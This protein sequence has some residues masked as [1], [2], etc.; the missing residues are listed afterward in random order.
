MAASAIIVSYDSF[1]ESVGSPP[2]RVILF[3]EIPTIIPSIS[4]VAPETSTTALIISSVALVIETTIVASPTRLCGLVPYLDSDSDSPDEMDS[5]EYITPLPATSPFLYT[6]SSEASDSSD[7][8]LLQDPYAI[9][10][11]RW[12]CRVTSRRPYRTQP[13]GPRRVMTVRKKVGPLPARRLSW[14]HV[15]PRS[16]DHR[17]SSSSSPTDSSPVHSSGLD[18]TGQAHSGSSTRVVSPRLGYLPVRATRHSEAFR[19][20]CAALLSIFYPPTTSESSSGDSSER[21]MHSSSHSAGPSC[22]RCRSSA[23]FIPSSTLVMG[24]LAPTHVD[25]LPPR[26]RFRDSYSSKTSMDEDTEI[27]TTETEDGRELDIVDGDDVRDHIEVDPRDDRRSLRPVLEIRLCWGLIQSQLVEHIPVDMDGA[28]R[29]FYHHMSKVRV[30]RIVGIETTQR[31][32]EADQMIASEARAERD[33]VD[34]LRLHMSRSQEEFR[35]IHDDCDDLMRK[36]RRTMT[37]TRSGM[38]PAVIEEMINRRVAEALKAHE[39]NRNLGLENLNGNHNCGNGNGRNGNGGNGNGQGGNRNGDGRG[40]MPVARECTYQ[41]FMKCQPLNFKR[42]EGVVGLIRW[43]EKD[44]NSVSHQKLSGKKEIMKLMT[45]VYC[46]R[47]K[48]QK[49]ETKLWNLSLKNNDMATYTQRFQELT[50]MCTKMVLEEEDQVER[51]IQGFPDNIQGSVMATEPTRLQD[52]VRIANNMMD[53]KLKGYVVRNAENKRRLDANRRDDRG[54]KPS[55]K[56]QDT[57]DQNVTR[58]YTVDNNET[59][60]MSA[61]VATTQGT[62]GPNQRVNTCFECGAPGHYR[63]DCPKIKNQNRG[64]KS[65]ILEARGKAYVLGGGDA[66]LGSNIVTGTFILNDHRAYMLFDLGANRSFVSNTFSTLLD[67]TPSALDVSYAVELADGRTSETSVVLRGCTLGLLGHPFTIDLMPIDLGSFDVIIGMDWLAKNHAVIVCDEKIVRIPYGNEILIVQ[68]DKSDEKKSILSIISCVKAHN[69]V[70]DSE[71][72][73]VDPIKIESIKDWESPK[74]PTEI[75]QFLG[76]ASYYRRF[77]KGF[78]KIS[79]PMTKLTQKSMK[80][81]WDEKEETAF[82]ILK[83]KLCSALIFALPKGSENFMV[84]CDASHKGLGAVLIQR[85]KVIAYASCQLKIYEKNYTMHDLELG[86]VVFALKMY[87][88]YLYDTRCVVSTDHKSLQHI[89]DQN[90]LNMRQRRWLE[91]L[92][93]YDYEIRYH[94]GKE[95]VVADA[96]SRKVR[97][98]PLRFRALVLTIGLNLPVQILNAQTEARKEGNYKAEDLGGMIKKLESRSDGTICLKNRSWIPGFAKENDSMEKLTRHYL[99]ESLQESFGTQLDMSTTYHP[100]TD[101]QNERTIQTLEDMLCACVMDF[102]KGW[103]KHLPLIEFS[104]NN[105][106]HTSIKAAQFEA[107]YGRKFWSPVCWAEVGDAQ[108]GTVAYRLELPEQ[109]SRVQSTFYFSNLK[110][111]LSDELLAIPLDEIHVDNKLNFIEEPVKI[112]DHE[113]KRLKQSRIPIVKAS[114]GGVTVESRDLDVVELER[115]KE[116]RRQ[117]IEK[118]NCKNEMI[119]QKARSTCALE[120]DENSKFFHACINRNIRK[121]RLNGLMIDGTCNFKKIS[122]EEKEELEQDVKEEEVWNAIKLCGSKK[123]LGPDG[124]NFG[125][126]KLYW[127][128]SRTDLLKAIKWFWNTGTISGG[129]NTSFVTLIPKTQDPITLSDFRPI[130]LIGCY[131]M[132]IGKMLAER[133]KKVIHKVVWEEQ[134]GFIQGRYIL[135]GALIANEAYDYLKKQKK[136]ALLLKIDFKKAYDNINWKFIQRTLLQMGSLTPEF[137][138]ERWARQEAVSCGYFNGVKIGSSAIPVS[139]LQYADD[140]LIF[141]EWKES[142]ARNLMRI[143]ECV[144]QASGLKINLNK[145]KIYGIG[146]QNGEIEDFANRMGISP[147]KMPFTYLGIPIGVNMKRVDSWKIIVEKFKKRLG[148]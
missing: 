120:W 15:S 31:Q 131:Y 39:I 135:D 5:P 9:T 38:T 117:W 21:P 88:H 91:L 53:K 50:M 32:L 46:L 12:R 103:N 66:N 100:E 56:R 136:K 121:T 140:T 33:R 57:G 54:Q 28:I 79:K 17:P 126:L 119:R 78:S 128:I 89:L 44:E 62:L 55:F 11:A 29:D 14:R 75:R 87:R 104:Y 23:D 84:Y 122:S 51:F 142:N 109:L 6:D 58:A 1:D 113:V 27:D 36:L 67:I 139:H 45:E 43:C 72:I 111:C 71:G 10:V 22:K 63:K 129:C 37:I 95:N 134:N 108:V 90:E 83:Q 118:D 124:F 116:A 80:F 76:L 92:S 107:L 143:M 133:I 148:N 48:I 52:V 60:V 2:S 34:N 105:S 81:D 41:D 49:M 74:T 3:G 141:G 64:S 93:D 110:R 145:T 20:W 82:Q 125:F 7:G 94:P 68:G 144:K 24:S 132:I 16:S 85:E 102:R 99:K 70:I 69:H 146:V 13:N 86:A 106:Y 138:M 25:L 73:H 4:M 130:S 8:P 19:H 114:F 18:A 97:P 147:G 96:L 65:R 26:K 35:Q 115:W 101:G 112:R 123:A 47:N 127:I 98:K 61:I 137:K 30:D 59:R 42:T 40:D 77:I